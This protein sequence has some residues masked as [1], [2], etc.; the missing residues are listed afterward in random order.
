M[1]EHDLAC[2][3]ESAR[4][5][6]AESQ[7]RL[8]ML[9][10]YGDGVEEDNAAA[11]ALLQKAAGQG[12]VE[13]AYNLGICYHYGF[14]VGVDLKAAYE[15]Y[16]QAANA[17]HGKGMELVG[18]FCY[19]GLYGQQ[20]YHAAVQWFT[21]AAN[22]ADPVAVAFAEYL[23]GRCYETGHG[24]GQS[25]ALAAAYYRSAVAHGDHGSDAADALRRLD[26]E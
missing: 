7:Y 4:L 22:S 15:C 8:A 2:L 13:A 9:H 12:H 1:R 16:L 20:D 25:R 23:L 3:R 14:G 6:D 24:V 26:P 11:F 5:G 21:A 18:L 10:I 17:G 19:D